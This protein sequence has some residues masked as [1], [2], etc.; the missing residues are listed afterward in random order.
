MMIDKILNSYLSLLPGNQSDVVDAWVS[1]Y[2][3]SVFVVYL[4]HTVS[5]CFFPMRHK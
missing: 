5:N 2:V 3:F 4:V 1:G